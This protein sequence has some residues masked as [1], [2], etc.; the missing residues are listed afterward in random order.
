MTKRIISLDVLRFFAIFLVLLWHW[1]PEKHII[2][3]MGNGQLGVNIFFVLS[4]FLIT[5]GLLESKESSLY[6]SLK[7]FYFKRFL[8]IFPIYY[9]L[10]MILVLI[11][12]YYIREV[13]CYYWLY[14]VNIYIELYN[15]FVPYTIHFWSLCVEEQFYLIW[16]ILS[17]FFLKKIYNKNILLIGI[18]IFSL[19]FGFVYELYFKMPYL[20]FFKYFYPFA[21]GAIIYVNW[22]YIEKIKTNWLIALSFLM[23]FLLILNSNY[24]KLQPGIFKALLELFYTFFSSC[25][26]IFVIKSKDFK[27]YKNKFFSSLAWIGQ[28]SY[29]VYLFHYFMFPLNHFLHLQCIEH[30]LKIPFTSI[31]LIPELGNIYL[32]FFYFLFCTLIISSFSFYLIEKPILKLSHRK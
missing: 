12:Y 9:I 17:L 3:F 1:M 27:I 25:L 26:L 18:S 10:V 23:L 8:R 30:N 21:F 29:G 7:T 2:N 13:Q 31:V 11:N 24:F 16:P 14:A 5:K 22:N 19:L 20:S 15:N 28:I 4:G 32:R 6:K